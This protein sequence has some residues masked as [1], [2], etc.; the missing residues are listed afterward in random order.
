MKFAIIANFSG[1][2]LPR[3]IAYLKA[4]Q[5]HAAEAFEGMFM[6]EWHYGVVQ[7]IAIARILARQEGKLQG[8]ALCTTCHEAYRQDEPS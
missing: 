1:L 5:R 4:V 7:N 8:A 3:P 2:V 6:P